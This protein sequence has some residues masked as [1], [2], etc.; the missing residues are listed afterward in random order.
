MSLKIVV[1]VAAALLKGVGNSEPALQIFGW[2]QADL[3][4][5][6]IPGK[7]SASPVR[8]KVFRVIFV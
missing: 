7:F 4:V 1:T 3:F 6:L 8:R 2:Q 5:S